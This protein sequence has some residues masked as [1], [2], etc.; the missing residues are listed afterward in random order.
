MILPLEGRRAK[1]HVN[2]EKQAEL[3][4]IIEYIEYKLSIIFFIKVK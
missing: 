2:K 4:I 1:K 3:L